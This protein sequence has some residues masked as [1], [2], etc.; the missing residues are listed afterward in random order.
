MHTRRC[1]F[2]IQF[3][4]RLRQF[5][6]ELLHLRHSN[7]HAEPVLNHSERPEVARSNKDHNHVLKLSSHS[8]DVNATR[9]S[10]PR[11][12]SSGNQDQNAVQ[13]IVCDDEIVFKTA[14]NQKL[15]LWYV[16][17]F[18]FPYLICGLPHK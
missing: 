3:S 11:N 2:Q 16:T 10:P 14:S 15:P 8:E 9:L 7:R 13:Q 12:Y 5:G 4:R 1:L 6:Q 18:I 17:W